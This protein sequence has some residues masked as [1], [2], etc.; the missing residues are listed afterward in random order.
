MN[1]KT[2]CCLF[3]SGMETTDIIN[4]TYYLINKKSMHEVKIHLIKGFSKT[5][6]VQAN[7]LNLL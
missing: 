5:V 4:K 1:G 6:Y 7:L 2:S 3:S